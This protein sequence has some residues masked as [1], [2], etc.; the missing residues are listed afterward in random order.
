MFFITWWEVRRKMYCKA[1]SPRRKMTSNKEI[2][3]S[4]RTLPHIHNLPA[5]THE[6]GGAG[7]RHP[8]CF[9]QKH[10]GWHLSRL[11]HL[12]QKKL[13]NTICSKREGWT[14]SRRR[15]SARLSTQQHC[16]EGRQL[17]LSGLHCPCC[18]F[19]LPFPHQVCRTR[20]PPPST[21]EWAILPLR[22]EW[23]NGWTSVF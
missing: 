13:W 12:I 21:S 20:W 4:K 8:S 2:L 3:L 6:L 18:D 9:S 15:L 22:N 10:P 1:S 23:F 19:A 5:E 14:D 16:G 7:T 17:D 11:C